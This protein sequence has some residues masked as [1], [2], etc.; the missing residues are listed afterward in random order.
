MKLETQMTGNG[1]PVVL[2]P[3]GLTG[4]ISWISHAEI[5]AKH[6]RVVRAQL[7]GVALGLENKPL[8]KGYGVR[9]ESRA[10]AEALEGLSLAPFHLVGW[11]FGAEVSLDY[12]LNHPERI[13]TLTLIEPP[14]IWVQRAKGPLPQ[15]V[16]DEQKTIAKLGPKDVGED[17]LAW[18][19]HFAG[20]VPKNVDPRTLPQWP[21]WVKHRQSLR[22]GDVA[23][24][25][26]DSA[27]RLRGFARPTLLVKGTGSAPF[28]HDIINTLAEMLPMNRVVELPGGH[29][30]Q[31]VAKDDF[32]KILAEFFVQNS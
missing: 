3:G 16:L 7:L 15:A 1:D 2:M 8:P 28:L 12:A 25:H 22:T 27:E 29:A 23:F 5:L 20:F 17:Q 24:R 11:S 31:L 6:Y 26:E 4:W 10:L 32:L 19:T 9:Y 30:P 13:R 14:A 21:A 18:F